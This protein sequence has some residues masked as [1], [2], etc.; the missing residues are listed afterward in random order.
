[1]YSHAWRGIGGWA[2]Q[3]RVGAVQ[4]MSRLGYWISSSGVWVSV[5]PLQ[6]SMQAGAQ[7]HD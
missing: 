6:R 5:L 3:S 2:Q 7:L 4:K 1:M